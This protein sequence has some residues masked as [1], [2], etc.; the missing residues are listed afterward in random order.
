M[1]CVYRCL[2]LFMFCVYVIHCSCFLSM[3]TNV[4]VLCL[5]LPLF[6]FSVHV[7][8]CSCFV[9]MLTIV[10]VL[11][12]CLS[13]F[14]FCIYDNHFSCFGQIYPYIKANTNMRLKMQKKKGAQLHRAYASPGNRTEPKSRF[15]RF[16]DCLILNGGAGEGAVG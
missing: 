4:H 3:L 15:S 16:N 12:L 6:L 7:N 10:Q 11:C 13:L 2:S 8:H 5:Y 14:M 1:F 9:S